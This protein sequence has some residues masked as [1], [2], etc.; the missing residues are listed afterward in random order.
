MVDTASPSSISFWRQDLSWYVRQQS[1][2]ESFFQQDQ[3]WT[4]RLAISN[5]PGPVTAAAP[6]KE[7]ADAPS[8]ADQ[9]V[10]HLVN[11]QSGP[12]STDAPQASASGATSG[13]L[14]NLLA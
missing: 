12:P 14:V 13:S 4:Q 7:P 3:S 10:M 8:I 2:T 6:T 1:W 9:K 11:A 5:S